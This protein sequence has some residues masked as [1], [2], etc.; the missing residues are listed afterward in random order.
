M[1]FSKW[2]GLGNDF[3]FVDADAETGI[4]FHA[5]A[6]RVCDRHFGIGADGLV[7]LRRLGGVRFEM[8]IINSD[9]SEAEMCGNATRCMAKYIY[10]RGL[11]AGTRFELDTRA[12]VIRPELYGDQVRVDMG[13]PV[14][15]A[16]PE[17]VVCC[18]R[19]FQGLRVSMGNPHFVIPVE[20]MAAVPLSEWGP[21]IEVHEF[22]PQ[23]TN[24]E[25]VQ[26]LNRDTL[27]MRVWERGCGVTLACGTG[28]CAAAVAGVLAG[29]SDRKAAVRLDGGTLFIEW[30]Q[31]DRHVYMSGDAREVFTGDYEV[32]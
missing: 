27:R 19:K 23:K 31:A 12:G 5:I 10:S 21:Q 29:R 6:S 9:G 30:S 13:E 8:R 1:K 16:V 24:V 15:S 25:F 32:C 3:V 4:D 14:W 18:G 26:T 28:S 7:T 17:T 22:F 20:D 2:Q 11:A